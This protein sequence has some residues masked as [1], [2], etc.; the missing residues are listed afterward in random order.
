MRLFRTFFEYC[1]VGSEFG[2]SR[3]GDIGV[4]G[5]I[6]VVECGMLKS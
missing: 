1:C 2:E 4:V 6:V 3:R 5:D